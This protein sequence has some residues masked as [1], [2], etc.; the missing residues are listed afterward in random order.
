MKE[1]GY[2]TSG[3]CSA[4]PETIETVAIQVEPNHPLRQRNRALP[5]SALFEVMT[6]P[7][8]RAGK[9]TEG[10]PGFPWAVALSGP[11][12]VWMLGKNVHARDLEASLADKGVARVCIGRQDAPRPQRRE[13]S[14]IARASTAL[15]KDGVEESHALR[16]QG[17]R[18]GGCAAVRILSSE[19]TAQAW[20]L[21]SPNAPGLWRGLAPRCGRAC[22]QLPTRAVVGVATARAQVQ[23]IRRTVQAPPLCVKGTQAKR[24]VWTRWLPAVG[25]F[26]VPTRLRV[27]G[28]GERRDRGL[29]H[30]ITPRKTMHEVAQRLI[31][32]SVPWSTPGV[33]A[34]GTMVPVGVTQAR[35]LGRPKA[36]QEGE[37]GLPYLRSRL[38]G[39]YGVGP[40]IR[41]VMDESKRL[42]QARAGSR[43][44][45]GAHATPALMVSDRGGDATAPL[46]AL[47]NEGGKALG[48]PPKGQGA[49]HVA[50]AVRATVRSER[51][52]TAGIMGTL[53]TATYGFNTPKERLWQTRE[54]AGPRSLLSCNLHKVM[55]ELGRADR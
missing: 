28:L 38:G 18:E 17:A 49:W 25:A 20:P 39:G 11:L 42:W 21:G 54:M 10:R 37:C 12:V 36:G 43:A 4:A 26:G 34:Q 5:W 40:L 53:K 22:A 6:R 29:P 33:V 52:K 16:R 3:V 41:G 47:A 45:C 14:N 51:G 50:E 35:A 13:P 19:T 8:R 55:R 7:G 2:G 27:Q 23:T 32:Q 24:Q 48:I 31:P 44:S 46:R 15:G 30:A 1:H 9:H